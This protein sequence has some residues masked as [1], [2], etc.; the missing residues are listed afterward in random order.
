MRSSSRLPPAAFTHAGPEPPGRRPP[1]R[2]I[3]AVFV[4]VVLGGGVVVAVAGNGAAT[5]PVPVRSATPSSI[6]VPS[7]EP[8]DGEAGRV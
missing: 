7:P 1:W 3:V 4:A 5:R 2:V 8:G 6:T